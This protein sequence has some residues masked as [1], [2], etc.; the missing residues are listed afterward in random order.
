MNT[1]EAAQH[2]EMLA[3]Q[4]RE[5][6]DHAVKAGW[7]H[8]APYNARI[9]TYENTAKVIRLQEET[10]QAHCVCHLVPSLQCPRRPKQRGWRR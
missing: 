7:G 8:P 10:G 2:W 9:K 6:R 5:A 1:E 4:Q 3:Q